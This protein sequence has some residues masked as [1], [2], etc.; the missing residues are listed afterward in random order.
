MKRGVK[1]K[2]IKKFLSGECYICNSNHLLE[3]GSFVDKETF[4]WQSKN[5]RGSIDIDFLFQLELAN[6]VA[7]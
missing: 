1:K 5:W 7:T 3:T 2:T 4:A 6:L